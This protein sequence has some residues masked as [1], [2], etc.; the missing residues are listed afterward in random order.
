MNVNT[1]LVYDDVAFF[2]NIQYYLYVDYCVSDKDDC[3]SIVCQNG[4]KCIDGLSLFTCQCEPDFEGTLCELRMYSFCVSVLWLI[5]I[6]LSLQIR[7][8]FTKN[9]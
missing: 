9:N 3:E 7:L 8:I 1:L 2:V 4:G 6:L 5:V